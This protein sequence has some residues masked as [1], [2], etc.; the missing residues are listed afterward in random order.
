MNAAG[1][2]RI[3]GINELIYPGPFHFNGVQ[4][5]R[6]VGLR[7]SPHRASHCPAAATRDAGAADGEEPGL[8]EEGTGCLAELG[9]RWGVASSTRWEG[10]IHFFIPRPPPASLKHQALGYGLWCLP[11]AI[12]ASSGPSPRWKLASSSSSP[13]EVKM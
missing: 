3:I 13:Q 5:D 12:Q 9:G 10:K 7:K 4:G 1:Y 2:V 6:R 8:G 11:V